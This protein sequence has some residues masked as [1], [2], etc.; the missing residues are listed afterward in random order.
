MKHDSLLERLLDERMYSTLGQALLNDTDYQKAEKE[1]D[2]QIKKLDKTKLN[3]KQRLAVDRV[4]SA[5]NFLSS[6]YGRAAYWQGF[7]DCLSLVQELKQ[8]KYDI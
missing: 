1:S 4:V 6:E 8:L 7:K 2:R 5:S 3:K